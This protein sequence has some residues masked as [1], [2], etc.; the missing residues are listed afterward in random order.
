VIKSVRLKNLK[1]FRDVRVDLGLRNI[2]V[3]PNMSG[4]S[5]FV[6][7]LRLLRRISYPSEPGTWGLANAFPGGFLE[8]TWKGG[9]SNLMLISLEGEGTGAAGSQNSEWIYELVVVGDERGS[10]RVQE[11]RLSLSSHDL[12]DNSGANRSLVNVDGRT[13]VKSID[14][15]RSSL[16]LD[17]PDWDGSFLRASLAFWYFYRLI[18][19]RMR[20]A[21]PTTAPRFLTELGDNLSSWLM[22]LQTTYRDAFARI[23]QV[24]R[25][26]LP[27]FAELFTRPT[28]FGTVLAGSRERHLQRPV[29]VWDMSDGELAFLALLS[30]IFSPRDLGAN[31]YCIEEPENHL[32]PR[33]IETLMELLQQVQD[34]LG[35]SGSA[36][37]IATTHSPYLVD[38]A[39]LDE[40]IVFE[41]RDGAT[42]VTYP[43]DKAHLRELLQNEELGLADLFYSGA[44]QSE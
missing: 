18:P 44:L 1:S 36:Q 2:L 5:N 26:V 9:E 30:L 22:R 29:P 39:D 7:A 25:D 31:L 20:Q 15:G 16:E 21:N 12:I 37:V 38:K 24:C 8:S 28:Q 10:I 41:K 13:I 4:K 6:E 19:L 27:G 40:L 14:P 17:S 32:H 23:E 33:L 3:G 35:P 11:E 43:K 42:A 34:E